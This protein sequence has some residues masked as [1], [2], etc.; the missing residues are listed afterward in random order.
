MLRPAADFQIDFLAYLQRLFAEGE[1]TATY[2]FALLMALADLAVEKGMDDD[3][4]LQLTDRD[5]AKKFIRY[6]SR[7]VRPFPPGGPNAGASILHQNTG[8]QAAVVNRVLEAQGPYSWSEGS[9]TSRL[10][11]D[12]T[13]VSQV[14]QVVRVM[15]LWKLQ[16]LGGEV[17]DFLYPNVGK[18]SLIELRPGICFCFRRFHG[19]VHRMA[20]ENWIRFIRERQKNQAILGGKSDLETFLFGTGRGNLE[21]Y[22]PLLM[23]LQSGRCFYC[24]KELKSGEVDH[25][26]P[27]S[28]YSVDLGHNFV[29]ACR[30]CNGHKGDML[31]APGHLENWWR[32]NEDRGRIMTE[33]FD[34]RTL[35]HDLPGIKWIARWAYEQAAATGGKGWVAGTERQDI[36]SSLIPDS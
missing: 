24:A 17:V 12:S 23:D 27:W 6:Y 25:F 13:L 15:P 14:A 7:Q 34:F 8:P 18:G 32:R 3:R 28:R 4:P 31:A 33:F 22:R 11:R 9:T 10:L 35:P 30:S 2:K 29:L 1:F 26:I 20:Q 36:L 5:S 21:P 19:F 16:A